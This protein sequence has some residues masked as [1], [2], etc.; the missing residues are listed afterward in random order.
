MLAHGPGGLTSRERRTIADII[1]CFLPIFPRID[2][3]RRRR[4]C[5]DASAFAASQVGALPDFLRGPY[6]LA[7]AAFE[8]LPLLRWGRRFARLDVARRRAYLALW[9]DGPLE[10][11]RNFVKLIRSCALLA[12]YDHP[13]L[14]EALR[15][16]VSAGDAMGK[17][18]RHV[19]AGS[20]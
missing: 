8:W 10:P 13:A 20:P 3:D 18:L 9:S 2:D 11:T 19:G 12:Y 17:P 15:A 16:Q 5:A 6:R 14:Q 4:I 1:G 7:L